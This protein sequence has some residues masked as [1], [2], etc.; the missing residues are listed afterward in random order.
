MDRARD[1]F[2]WS[3]VYSCVVGVFSSIL[4]FAFYWWGCCCCDF[5][6][7]CCGNGQGAHHCGR[8]PCRDSMIYPYG[9]E[10][11]NDM[12]MMW[13]GDR[14]SCVPPPEESPLATAAATAPV[15]PVP[16][17]AQAQ[18][19]TVVGAPSAPPPAAVAT[20]SGEVDVEVGLQVQRPP[21]Q[22]GCGRAKFGKHATCCT[23]CT[24]PDG[25][26]T[27]DCLRKSQQEG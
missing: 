14:C 5:C 16:V 22:N 1:T 7:I 18:A 12:Q 13:G 20:S 9:I 3:Q 2:L 10:Y 4:L 15:A 19:A 24:G 21:C 23:R 6:R 8:E 25:P 11:P 17:A 27:G 26:H